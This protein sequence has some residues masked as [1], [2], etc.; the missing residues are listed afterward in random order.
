MKRLE[1]IFESEALLHVI[2]FY[3]QDL[4]FVNLGAG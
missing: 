4:I 1:D 3:E 2:S